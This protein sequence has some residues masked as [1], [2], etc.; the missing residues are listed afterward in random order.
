MCVRAACFGDIGDIFLEAGE[1]IYIHP[2]GLTLYALLLKLLR[3]DCMS[4]CFCSKKEPNIF[5]LLINKKISCSYFIGSQ[6]GY[7]IE[8]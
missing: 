8:N 1:A 6:Y 5:Y 4:G 7:F 3:I 2:I